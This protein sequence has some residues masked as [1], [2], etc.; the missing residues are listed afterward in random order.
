MRKIDKLINKAKLRVDSAIMINDLKIYGN[1][2]KKKAFQKISYSD[3]KK[4][5]KFLSILEKLKNVQRL[6]PMQLLNNIY[7]EYTKMSKKIIANDSIKKHIENIYKSSDEGKEIK[8]KMND[9]NY[10]I[11]K[12][13]SKNHFDG[14]KLKNK[15][16]QFDL[17]ID[18]INE[19]NQIP[20]TNQ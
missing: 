9:K 6:A 5:I 16:K 7:E 13:I 18:K 3:A 4:R 20:P 2:K 19:E 10:I 8:R 14:I 11:N 1:K 17:V 12:I 15:Y